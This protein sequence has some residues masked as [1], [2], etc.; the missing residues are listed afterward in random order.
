MESQIKAESGKA[1]F[2]KTVVI[3][4]NLMRVFK[5]EKSQRFNKTSWTGKTRIGLSSI[6]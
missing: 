3:M 2:R 6:L 5:I 1:S 4:T